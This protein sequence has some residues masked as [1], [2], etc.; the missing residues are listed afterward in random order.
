LYAYWRVLYR[1]VGGGVPFAGASAAEVLPQQ[2]HDAPPDLVK[3]RAD[4]PIELAVLVNALLAKDPDERPQA[5][6]MVVGE[7]RILREKLLRHDSGKYRAIGHTP[8]RGTRL[9]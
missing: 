7:L 8:A 1:F 5:C 9:P 2:L 4:T 3:L 6:E